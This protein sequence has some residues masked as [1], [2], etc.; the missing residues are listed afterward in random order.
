MTP[1]ALLICLWT[2]KARTDI[3]GHFF[4]TKDCKLRDMPAP[5][6]LMRGNMIEVFY[7]RTPLLMQNKQTQPC[8]GL[9]LKVDW[10]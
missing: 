4:T 8:E 6:Q 7:Y 1:P 10:F 9:R 3:E 5:E 2:Q